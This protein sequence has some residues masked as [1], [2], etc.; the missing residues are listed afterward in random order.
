MAPLARTAGLLAAGLGAGYWFTMSPWSQ[1][2]GSFVYR[3]PTAEPLIALTFDDG[4]NPPFTERLAD[5]LAGHQ[6]KATFFQV[7]ANAARHPDTTR[8]LVAE[9]H[10]VGNHS[11]SHDPRRLLRAADLRDQISRTQQLLGELTGA[12]PTLY[13]PPWLFRHPGLFAE[14]E[15]ADLDV[16]GGEFCHPAEVFQPDP[17]VLVEGTLRIAR[18]GLIVV[19]HD[20]YNASGAPRDRTVTAIDR[21]IPRLR[22]RGYRFVTVPELLAVPAAGTGKRFAV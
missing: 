10:V 16:V 17:D 20:G 6:V 2:L 22:E 13:R 3:V 5:V 18:P 9:G 7:G 21:L 8:R 14:L 11:W 1:R 19:F 12:A 4:P 15:R